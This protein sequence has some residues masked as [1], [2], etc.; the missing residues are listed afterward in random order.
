MNKLTTEEQE[1]WDK[2]F[3][4]ILYDAKG[5]NKTKL[6]KLLV[7]HHKNVQEI[8][9]VYHHVTGGNV[10]D[11]TTPAAKVIEIIT[12]LDNQNLEGILKD[13]KEKWTKEWA[14]DNVESVT[15]TVLVKTGNKL[16]NGCTT[17]D[18]ITPNGQYGLIW[19]PKT[20]RILIND[21]KPLP[22]EWHA[23]VQGAVIQ[24]LNDKEKRLVILRK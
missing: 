23:T 17:F 20:Q 3:K 24:L 6:I 7:A 22:P 11:I 8:L 21:K 14:Y 4:P 12:D 2:V 1:T 9:K 19:D 15:D 18:A 5:L 16:T 10:M 13:E